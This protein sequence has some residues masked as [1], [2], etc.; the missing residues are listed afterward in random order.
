[1]TEMHEEH[2][3]QRFTYVPTKVPLY[4]IL[5]C[6]SKRLTSGCWAQATKCAV[7]KAS[8]DARPTADG[9][10]AFAGQVSAIMCNIVSKREESE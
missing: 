5:A 8:K 7:S 2:E 10:F 6:F 3:A 9:S 4:L 1:M